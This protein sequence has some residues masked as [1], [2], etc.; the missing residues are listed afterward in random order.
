[1]SPPTRRIGSRLSPVDLGLSDLDDLPEESTP[2]ED[3]DPARL[4]VLRMIARALASSDLTPKAAGRDGHRPRPGQPYGVRA[5]PC[6]VRT[7][8]GRGWDRPGWDRPGW[9]R[10]GWERPGWERPGWERPGWERLGWGRAACARAAPAPRRA[11][12]RAPDREHGGSAGRRGRLAAQGRLRPGAG[13]EPG[14]PGRG[15]TGPPRLLHRGGLVR[16]LL[17]NL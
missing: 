5:R 16:A 4:A 12:A 13:A 6:G 11:R 9:D 1:M 3:P 14:C 17:I 8:G 2:A 7:G 10:P 15:R